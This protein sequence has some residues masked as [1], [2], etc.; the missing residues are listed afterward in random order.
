M[1]MVYIL[2]FLFKFMS[3]EQRT[4]LSLVVA[5]CIRIKHPT[6]IS[7]NAFGC[8]PQ[9]PL[10]W[11]PALASSLRLADAGTRA[12]P[13]SDCKGGSTATSWHTSWSQLAVKSLCL[14]W[15]MKVNPPWQQIIAWLALNE[16]PHTQWLRTLD[17]SHPYL[18]YNAS[19][20]SCLFKWKP[21]SW[22][23]R[24]VNQSDDFAFCAQH[25]NSVLKQWVWTRF[26]VIKLNIEKVL[27]CLTEITVDGLKRWSWKLSR[28]L[29]YQG[30][31]SS[32]DLFG[33]RELVVTNLG[34]NRYVQ[35]SKLT[36]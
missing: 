16:A 6:V 34:G 14:L 33:C 2:T 1:N 36:W 28:S 9:K 25:L 17:N 8:L 31:Q 5:R 24:V 12:S 30:C 10:A 26:D 7:K 32:T 27:F 35:T 18:N 21:C 4:Y 29:N 15:R 20:N 22:I 19:W 23:G 11:I 13:V 3:M